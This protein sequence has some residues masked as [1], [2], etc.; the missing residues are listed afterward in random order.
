[1]EQN[2]G[3]LSPKQVLELLVIQLVDLPEKM[4]IKELVGDQSITLELTVAEKDIGKVIGKRGRTAQAIRDI[5]FCV[6]ARDKKRCTLNI[7]Q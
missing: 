7:N 1:M 6:A 5:L 3:R 4:S 2:L